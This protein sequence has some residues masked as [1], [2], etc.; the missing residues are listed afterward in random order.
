MRAEANVLVVDDDVDL[1]MM[2]HLYLSSRGFYVRGC[3]S[4]AE[5]QDAMEE[6]VPDVVVLDLHMPQVSGSELVSQCQGTPIVF[7]SAADEN[8]LGQLASD[9]PQC[10]IVNKGGALSL[11]EETIRSALTLGRTVPPPADTAPPGN[12]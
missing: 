3:S 6:C 2:A 8:S 5:F 7:F 12:G 11:L 9:H 1:L 4:A 10:L